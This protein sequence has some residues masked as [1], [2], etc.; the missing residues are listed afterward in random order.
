MSEVSSNEEL[1]HIGKGR[2]KKENTRE[3]SHVEDHQYKFFV[4]LRHEKEVLEQILKMLK[5]A[6]NKPY[7]KEITFR[8]LAV[9]AVPKLTTKDIEKIQEGSLNEMERVQRLLDEH[10]EKNKTSLSLG[11]F[12]VKKL[13]I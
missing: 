3:E 1:K 7:G 13:N 8:D 6:N 2:K 12:L 9:Y 4:D 10:N 5:E 11:E